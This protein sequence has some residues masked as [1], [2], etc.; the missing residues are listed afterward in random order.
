MDREADYKRAY[1]QRN[2]ERVKAR[3]R[4]FM[5]ARMSDWRDYLQSRYGKPSCQL[6]DKQLM[7]FGL[8]PDKSSTV[9][10]DHRHDGIEPIACQP[11][12]WMRTRHCTP[13]NQAIFEKCDFGILCDACN[14]MLPTRN[15]SQWL[16][17]LEAYHGDS[18]A[19]LDH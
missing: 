12:K 3:S 2:V 5:D 6:C 11:T 8:T 14:R 17:K 15:R 9:H 4:R 1:Y 19:H 13:E 10:F 7:W 16:A 18:K